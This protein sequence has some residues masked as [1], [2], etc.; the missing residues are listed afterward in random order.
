MTT[1]TVSSAQQHKEHRGLT[2][3]RVGV[4][5]AKKNEQ[6]V[7]YSTQADGSAGWQHFYVDDLLIAFQTDLF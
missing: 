6:W 1:T 5:V 4:P 3:T 2:F 7:V